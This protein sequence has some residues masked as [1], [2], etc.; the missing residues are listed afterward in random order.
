MVFVCSYLAAEVD[1]T[2][3]GRYLGVWLVETASMVV[4]TGSSWEPGNLTFFGTS[5]SN[6]PNKRHNVQG[7][8]V[9]ECIF[10]PE[11]VSLWAETTKTPS[12]KCN[13]VIGSR[14]TVSALMQR[15]AV[16][17]GGVTTISC[18]VSGNKVMS[19]ADSLAYVAHFAN[20]FI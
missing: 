16:K 8:G 7:H 3:G 13:I 2:F 17:M 6:A 19:A 4:I 11:A 14:A 15:I 9:I 18:L 5:D 1:I 12:Y 10:A 20:K